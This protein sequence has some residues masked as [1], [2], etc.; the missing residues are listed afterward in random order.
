MVQGGWTTRSTATR[1][2]REREQR[3]GPRAR[4][5]QRRLGSPQLAQGKQPIT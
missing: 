1:G 4:R 5:R 2:G 3:A